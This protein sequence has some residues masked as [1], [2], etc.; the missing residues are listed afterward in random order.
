MPGFAG[1]RFSDR[2]KRFRYD[3]ICLFEPKGKRNAGF[4]PAPYMEFCT[5][6]FQ[7]LNMKFQI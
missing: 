2:D 5:G 6:T 4:A 3:S 1:I 7:A